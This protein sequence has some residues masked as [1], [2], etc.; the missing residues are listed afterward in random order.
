MKLIGQ[1][2]RTSLKVYLRKDL[3]HVIIQRRKYNSNSLHLHTE[4]MERM[5]WLCGQEWACRFN[6]LVREWVERTYSTDAIC[7]IQCWC[8]WIRELSTSF[9]SPNI[10]KLLH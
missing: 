1:K 6:L 7:H 10:F 3:Y 9:M 4:R 5:D 8:V 2:A